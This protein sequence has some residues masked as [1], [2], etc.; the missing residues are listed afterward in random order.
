MKKKSVMTEHHLLYPSAI[1]HGCLANTEV[2]L[3]DVPAMELIFV[4]LIWCC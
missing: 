3:A 4:E 2:V 1:K